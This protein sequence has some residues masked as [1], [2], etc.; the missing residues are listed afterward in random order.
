MEA[1]DGECLA[2]RAG[3][4]EGEKG[5]RLPGVPQRGCMV[6]GEPVVPVVMWGPGPL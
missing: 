2:P 4:G 3:G 5:A 1:M 6:A